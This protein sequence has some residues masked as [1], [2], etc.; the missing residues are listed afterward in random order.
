MM[1]ALNFRIKGQNDTDRA[2]ASVKRNLRGIEGALASVGERATRTGRS[3]RNIGAGLT[4]A[5]TAPAIMGFKSLL[6]AAGDFEQS[7]NRVRSL[8]G[9]VGSDFQRLE[10]QAKDLGASTK[11]SATQ[12]ADA[13]GFLAMAGFDTDQ[14]IGAMPSTLQLAASAN[15]ELADAADIV[16]NA[17]TG[18]RKD[19]SDLPAVT[20]AM[21]KGFTSA[22]MD[23][24]QLGEAMVPLGPIASSAGLR[25]NEMTAAIGMLGNA[26]IQGEKAGNTLK[27]AL[28]NLLDPTPKVTAELERLGVSVTKPN[29]QLRDLSDILQQL[30]PH[31][32]DTAAILRIF[33]RVAGPGMA[34]LLAQGSDALRTFEQDL[35]NSTGTAARI[36]AEQMQGLNGALISLSSAYEGLKIAIASSGILEW[37]TGMVQG[38]TEFLRGLSDTNPAILKFGTLIVGLTAVIGPLVAVAGLATIGISAFA[39]AL[40]VAAAPFAIVLGLLGG[41]AALFYAFAENAGDAETATYDAAIGTSA[42]NKQLGVFSTTGAPTA[43]AA[44]IALAND[45]YTLAQSSFDA[46][47]AELARIRAFQTAGRAKIGDRVDETGMSEEMDEEVQ[48]YE[49]RLQKAEAALAEAERGRKRA[50]SSVTGSTF[51]PTLAAIKLPPIDTTEIDNSLGNIGNKS[52]GSSGGGAVT[53]ANELAA[54]YDRVRSSLDSSYQSAKEF[55]DAEQAINDAM[56]A[57]II[58]REQADADLDRLRKKYDNLSDAQKRSADGATGFFKSI[59]NGSKTAG[60]AISEMLA[61]LA[62]KWLTAGLNNMFTGLLGGGGGG[63]LDFLFS[64]NGNVFQNGKVSAFANGGI[65]NSTTAFQ[66][67]SGVGIM[68][69]A[70]PEAIMPLERVGGKLGVR[71]TGSAETTVIRLEMSPDVE[72]RIVAEAVNQS[73]MQT[74]QIVGVA[75]SEQQKGLRGSVNTL[76]E[77]GTST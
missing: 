69:E 54:A 39:G 24:L 40:A 61:Q 26:G 52:S 76:S 73:A 44:A 41:S 65:V 2:F 17:L 56:D 36:A 38:L 5:V 47:R 67:G 8:S 22:N 14:I 6:S 10:Q 59:I 71:S 77:R 15:L 72:G 3:M 57:G 34:A 1:S 55:A 27:R 35:N 21:V 9:A 12:A 48:R 32:N 74:V 66:M 53:T 31:A 19:V 20:D 29:G 42:L 45:N 60:E 46:A 51:K 23:L 50:A 70:G 68:G 75:T 43:G 28:A 62:D 4:L 13:M 25:F 30:E 33:G 58:S 18:Y 11:F 64:A 49:A 37:V 16:S 7:M 63:W